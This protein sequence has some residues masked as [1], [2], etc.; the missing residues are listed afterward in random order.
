MSRH[1]ILRRRQ[2]PPAYSLWC[3]LTLTACTLSTLC[4]LCTAAH[5]SESLLF[6]RARS[7]QSVSGHP[8]FG[9]YNSRQMLSAPPIPLKSSTPSPYSSPSPSNT[10]FLNLL[11]PGVPPPKLRL[12]PPARGDP[13]DKDEP[14]ADLKISVTD[15]VYSLQA[16]LY[17]NM[18]SEGFCPTCSTANVSYTFVSPSVTPSPTP[19]PSFVPRFPYRKVLRAIQSVVTIRKSAEG[20]REPKEI[21]MFVVFDKVVW[22]K[23]VYTRVKEIMDRRN[24]GDKFYSAKKY[25]YRRRG[26]RAYL[27]V[28][29]FQRDFRSKLIY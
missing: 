7:D 9:Q 24:L 6:A 10:P 16:D 19:T 22:K 5:W 14:P 8:P 21:R 2:V 26:G 20:T 13:S 1:T 17:L 28:V 23:T 29:Y 18:S 27:V 12:E 15:F 4:R 11:P 3:S 25:L